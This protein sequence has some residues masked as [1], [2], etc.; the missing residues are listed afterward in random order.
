MCWGNRGKVITQSWNLLSGFTS[1]PLKGYHHLGHS[2]PPSRIFLEREAL[3]QHILSQT[4]FP[5]HHSP[6]NFSCCQK[7]ASNSCQYT[8][9]GAT[10]QKQSWVLTL[11]TDT[12]QMQGSRSPVAGLAL[13]LHTKVNFFFQRT[14]FS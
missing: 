2:H 5:S 7:A 6:H 8:T 9:G 12:R 1:L 10:C 3:F 11:R 14:Q 13:I 4:I